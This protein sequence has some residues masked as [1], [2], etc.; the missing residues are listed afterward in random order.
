MPPENPL[1]QKRGGIGQPVGPR[2]LR[3]P[4]TTHV[5]YP[6]VLVAH[7]DEEVR[8]TLV[9]CLQRNGFDVLEADDWAHVFDVVRVHSRL[10]HLL[11]AEA[12]KAELMPLL[13]TYRSEV[14]VVFVKEPVDADE[15]LAKVRQILGSPKPPPSPSSIR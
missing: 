2:D 7:G 3:P 12:S 9:D 5:D 1:R 4:G 15:V 11:L 6:T 8:S 14:K 10:I 13:K